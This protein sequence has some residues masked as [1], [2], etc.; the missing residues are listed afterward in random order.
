MM[1]LLE[2]RSRPYSS[3]NVSGAAYLSFQSCVKAV[4]MSKSRQGG[5]AL[6]SPEPAVRK[7]RHRLRLVICSLHLLDVPSAG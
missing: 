5:H 4:K 6:Y 3:K 7:G 2:T 1:R